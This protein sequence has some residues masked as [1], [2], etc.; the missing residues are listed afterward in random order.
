MGRPLKTAKLA[1][2]GTGFNN[3][4][5]EFNTYGVVGGDTAI[6]GPQIR[7]RVRIPGQAEADGFIV[8][9][10][11]RKKFLVEDAAGNRGVCFV[12][13]VNNL[14]LA[15]GDMTVAVTLSDSSVVRL[16]RI[17]NRWGVDFAGGKHLLTFNMPAADVN[18]YQL[19]E[20]DNA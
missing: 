14:A 5:G 2:K 8:R 12:A 11:G 20:V 3:P 4:A 19:V 15:E 17:S 18:G 13:D 16:E 9:Q 10:K 7:V 6:V 1:G